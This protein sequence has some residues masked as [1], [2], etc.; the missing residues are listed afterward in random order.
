[1]DPV[2]QELLLYSKKMSEYLFTVVGVIFK[3]FLFKI[4][5]QFPGI[6]KDSHTYVGWLEKFIA[7]LI[8]DR[9]ELII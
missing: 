2:S 6:L 8:S 3:K 7:I 9:I 5:F 4:G 1:M